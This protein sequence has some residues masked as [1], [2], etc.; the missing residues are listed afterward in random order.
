MSVNVDSV[1]AQI[2]IYAKELR[3]SGILG[4]YSKLAE[5]ATERDISHEGY[6]LA[7]LEEELRTRKENCL[8]RNMKAAKFPSLKTLETFDL[9]RQPG[10]SKS[11]LKALSESDF[12]AKKENVIL[13]GNSG[14][15]KS[16][17]A[18][19]LGVSAISN[20]YRVRFISAVALSQELL[21]AQDEHRLPAVL[22]SY[23]KYDLVIVD[24]LGYI[25]FGAG[26]S[27]LFQFF[28][29][30]YERG[31]VIVTTNLEF[32]KWTEVFT[33][34]TMTAALLDRLTHHASILL[35]Q[36]ESYRFMESSKNLKR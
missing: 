13:L 32:S 22:K 34:N 11:K 18:T 10:L 35:F 5:E 26:G 36:G 33:D 23:D 6:L 1:R 19:A 28:A 30:R 29:E 17:I 21:K 4:N 3:L 8:K 16:H 27:P 12:V 24:E 20:G 14:T 2:D 9:T 7:C 31:S 15:G 25:G